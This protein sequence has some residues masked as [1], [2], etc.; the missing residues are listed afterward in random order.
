VVLEGEVS[1]RLGEET[2]RLRAG[3]TLALPRGVPYAHRIDSQIARILVR[4][5]R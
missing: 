4:R 3:Q 2:H 1:V 5:A